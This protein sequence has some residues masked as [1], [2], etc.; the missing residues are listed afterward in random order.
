MSKTLNMP[1][2]FD[3][4]NNPMMC[5]Y[6]QYVHLTGD[7]VRRQRGKIICPGILGWIWADVEPRCRH[8]PLLELVLLVPP[9]VR[10][11]QAKGLSVLSP[12]VCTYL[13]DKENDERWTMV[14]V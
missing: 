6:Q 4:H 9:G 11:A 12:A 8:F 1:T 3:L 5:K 13:L 7:F 10:C 14:T 2:S